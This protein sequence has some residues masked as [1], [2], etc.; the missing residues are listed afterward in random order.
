M[1]LYIVGN[2]LLAEWGRSAAKKLKSLNFPTTGG[3]Q[4]L[5][6]RG[7]RLLA[8]AFALTVALSMRVNNSL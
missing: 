6:R 3:N 4:I 7:A 2:P 1:A 5:R 8:A